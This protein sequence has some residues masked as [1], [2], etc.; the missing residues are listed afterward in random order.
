MK[1]VNNVNF[2]A[3]FSALY[4]AAVFLVHLDVDHN[5]KIELLG[6]I[7]VALCIFLIGHYI[8]SRFL[9]KKD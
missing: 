8:C 1:I 7:T 2:I 5:G 3:V 9:F 4:I 6:I